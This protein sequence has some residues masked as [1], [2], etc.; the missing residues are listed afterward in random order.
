MTRRCRSLENKKKRPYGVMSSEN[1]PMRECGVKTVVDKQRAI[2]PCKYVCPSDG[3]NSEKE[4]VW[5]LQSFN[6][7]FVPSWIATVER[8]Y[9]VPYPLD[10][11]FIGKRI[12]DDLMRKLELL[13]PPFGQLHGD[14][15]LSCEH[16]ANA[17]ARLGWRNHLLLQLHTDAIAYIDSRV[18][19]PL[20]R[21]VAKRSYLK[22]SREIVNVCEIITAPSQLFADR[23][24]A[25]TGCE[26]E[27]EIFPSIVDIPKLLDEEARES[28]RQNFYVVNQIPV[29]LRGRP[30]MGGVSRISPEKSIDIAIRAHA[31]CVK[32]CKTYRVPVPVLIFVG[33]CDGRYVKEL[34]SLARRLGTENLIFFVGSR[35]HD[36]AIEFQQICDV[37]FLLSS[38]ETQGLV[39]REAQVTKSIPLVLSSTALAEGLDDDFLICPDYPEV[40]GERAFDFLS[41]EALLIETREHQYKV[42]LW[43]ND[44]I[45]YETQYLRFI[46]RTRR[47]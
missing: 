13:D 10:C 9:P 42:A 37:S 26:K 3:S 35:P 41:H 8:D 40:I 14:Q 19:S 45:R 28:F 29:E 15:N 33:E 27:I 1:L 6:L 2:Y 16:L 23:F 20:L 39:R 18:H 30:I 44:P 34:K 47:Y 22:R 43:E 25:I 36:Y 17:F 32:R 31:V 12:N 11:P 24:K 46:D 4:D 5:E 38:S 21:L 7:N